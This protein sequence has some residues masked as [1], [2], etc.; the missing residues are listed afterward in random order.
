MT[1]PEILLPLFLVAIAAYLIGSV[2]FSIICTHIF[3]GTDVRN[4]GSGNAGATNVL[5]TAGKL[6]ALLTFLGDFLKC[7]VAILLARFILILFGGIVPDDLFIGYYAGIFCMLGHIFPIFF[8]FR[9]GKAVATAGALVLMAD[10]R[11]FLIA[12]AVFAVVFVI[13]RIV[14]LSSIIGAL[15]LPFSTFAIASLHSGNLV[16]LDTLCACVV[17]FILIFKHRANIQ[18]LRNGTEP[19]IG[20]KNQ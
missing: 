14:S 9:G 2:S 12:F 3:A 13:S 19:R 20:R 6:P 11:L 16:W 8:G 1:T 18:R 17:A 10:W 7:V 4:H 15:S 5:R